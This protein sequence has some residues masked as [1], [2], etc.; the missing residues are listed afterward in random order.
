MRAMPTIAFDLV[1]VASRTWSRGS[2]LFDIWS[3]MFAG[4][5]GV[6]FKRRND[7]G[8]STCKHL[9][10]NVGGR[11]GGVHQSIGGVPLCARC[12]PMPLHHF[13]E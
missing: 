3:I 7:E 1:H 12:C 9:E 2:M 10:G 6:D 8:V 5:R 13:G 4:G 11:A